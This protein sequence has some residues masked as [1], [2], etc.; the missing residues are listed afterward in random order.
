MLESFVFFSTC[1]LFLLAFG[2]PGEAP[3]KLTQG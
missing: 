1:I 3:G 2:R